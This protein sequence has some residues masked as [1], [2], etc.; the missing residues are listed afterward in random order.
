LT[1]ELADSM[2]AALTD[3]FKRLGLLLTSFQIGAITPPEEVQKAIDQRSAIGAIGNMST[4]T[5]YQA[6]QAMRDA[7]ANPGGGAAATGAGLGAGVAIGQSMA[8]AIQS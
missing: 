1:R 4:F 6:A 3:D 2:K 7:A 8:Q 5:Q